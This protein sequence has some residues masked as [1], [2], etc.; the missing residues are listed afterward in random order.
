MWKQTPPFRSNVPDPPPHCNDRMQKNTVIQKNNEE[1]KVNNKK[2]RQ[3]EVNR[4]GGGGAT[5]GKGRGE[6]EGCCGQH[7]TDK[8]RGETEE[9]VE[10]NTPHSQKKI[11]K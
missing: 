7:R 11:I 5:W 1:R 9:C 10:E 6:R 3:K 8:T 2:L 4:V